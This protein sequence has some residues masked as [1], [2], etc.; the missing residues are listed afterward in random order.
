MSDNNYTENDILSIWINS[1][2]DSNAINNLKY[3]TGHS[4]EHILG[5]LNKN[6]YGYEF[7][8]LN[9]KI[10]RNENRCHTVFI[11]KKD[12]DMFKFFCF[13]YNV[14]IEDIVEYNGKLKIIINTSIN[15]KNRLM[16]GFTDYMKS[17]EEKQ[18]KNKNSFIRFIS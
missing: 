6:G 4:R 2:Q 3:L 7:T 10:D 8:K 9:K 16:D 18:R 12:Q 14:E 11:K 13:S 17:E 15:I 5:I 1:S